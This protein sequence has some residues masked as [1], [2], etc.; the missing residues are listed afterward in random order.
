MRWCARS[1]PTACAER[2]SSSAT[3]Y[4]R[5]SSFGGPAPINCQLCAKGYHLAIPARLRTRFTCTKRNR[6]RPCRTAT[7]MFHRFG[8]GPATMQ[9]HRR[10]CRPKIWFGERMAR[11]G[12]DCRDGLHLSHFIHADT[13]AGL[14]RVFPTESF[15]KCRSQPSDGELLL[16]S[17]IIIVACN[18][19]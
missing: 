1:S 4:K 12:R 7:P 17:L 18:S 5:R 6:L 14:V 3:R 15:S 19:K 2:G 9:C 13:S 16:S 10:V 8:C 11:P